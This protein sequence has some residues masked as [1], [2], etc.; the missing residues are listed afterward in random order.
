MSW[1]DILR[2]NAVALLRDLADG[3]EEPAAEP[4]SPPWLA[5]LEEPLP[6]SLCPYQAE[7]ATCRNCG[8]LVSRRTSGTFRRWLHG[9]LGL[10]LYGRAGCRAASFDRLGEWDDS[11]PTGWMAEPQPG[12]VRAE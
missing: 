10:E 12:T 5:E 1:N 6:V 7:R 11:L 2:R 8:Q 4:D 3:L 9:D